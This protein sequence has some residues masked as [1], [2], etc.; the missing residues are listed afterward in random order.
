[1]IFRRDALE[2]P[3]LASTDACR[4][5]KQNPATSFKHI[6]NGHALWAFILEIDPRCRLG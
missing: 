4:N 6:G 2:S 3:D 1:M 5:E